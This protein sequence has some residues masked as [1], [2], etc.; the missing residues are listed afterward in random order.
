MNDVSSADGNPP[1]PPL[2]AACLDRLVDGE[3]SGEEYR[4]ILR[5]LERHPDQWRRCAHAFLQAQAWQRDFGQY[6]APNES[7]FL[8]TVATTDLAL[9]RGPAARPNAAE[10]D[11]IEADDNEPV[12]SAT[13]VR[14][15]AK[16]WSSKRWSDWAAPVVSLASIGLAFL[17]GW[18]LSNRPLDTG[19]GTGTGPT[20]TRATDRRYVPSGH[21]RLAVDDGNSSVAVPYFHPGEYPTVQTAGEG[22]Q[23]TIESWLEDRP[24]DRLRAVMPGKLDERHD[25]LLPIE[26]ISIPGKT[27]FQ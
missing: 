14:V 1:D 19:V 9:S 8:E 4:E 12:D 18:S 16:S 10:P 6:L 20:L 5:A 23:E 15:P 26:M 11:D 21:V 27:D 7:S 13:G 3:V 25:V 22:Q 17:G 2:S 24:A